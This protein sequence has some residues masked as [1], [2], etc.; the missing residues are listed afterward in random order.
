MR[1][2]FSEF[3]AG[4]VRLRALLILCAAAGMIAGTARADT[5]SF[6]F[7]SNSYSGS[8]QFTADATGTAGE[9]LVTSIQGTM[10][11]GAG[12][13]AIAALLPTGSFGAND[14]LF[15]FPSPGNPF[16]VH[17]VTFG[18]A[19]ND[20]VNLFD[21]ALNLSTVAIVRPIDEFNGTLFP[22]ESLDFV[23]TEAVPVAATPEPSS[24]MLLGTGVLGVVGARRKRG[25]KSEK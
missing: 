22:A 11:E 1:Y 13:V 16:T 2:T 25:V 20:Q 19:N 8:G 14:N 17:G 9:F 24:L 10:N 21:V 18:L 5:F 15:L 4:S 7:S 6:S 3:S 23:A 12:D